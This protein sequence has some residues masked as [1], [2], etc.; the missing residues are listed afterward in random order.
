MKNPL[1]LDEEI[2]PAL[3]KK[4]VKEKKVDNAEIEK[5]SKEKIPNDYIPIKLASNGKLDAPKVLHFRDFS[6]DD[7]LELNVLDEDDRLK[8][9][10]SVI[11]GMCYENFDC[12]NLN[13]R[14]LIQILFTIH[15]TFISSKMRKEYYI[16]ETL[17]EGKEEGQLDHPSNVDEIDIA[18]TKLLVQDID[19]N[20]DGSSKELKFKEPF[21]LTDTVKKTKAKLRLSRI[22]DILLAQ[23]HCNTKFEDELKRF[24]PLKKALYKLIDIDDKEER[25]AELEKLIEDNE[26]DYEDYQNFINKYDKEYIRILQSQQIVAIDGVELKTLEEKIE[27]YKT[28]VSETLW[29]R[30]NEVVNEYVFGILDKYTFYCDKLQ[31]NITRRFLF[32]YMD[33]LPDID[34]DHSKRYHL[35]FD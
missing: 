10:I 7:A 4:P 27:A 32:Q 17:P 5:K 13:I 24:K 16:D 31:K 14:E 1:V 15:I 25:N 30:Y 3:A 11:S 6:M 9:L 33:F 19:D 18:L 35:S 8:A 22:K 21:T 29:S 12:T 28:N 26:D 23:E 2:S 34:K 20:P